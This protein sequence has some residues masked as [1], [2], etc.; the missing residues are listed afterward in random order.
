MG[1]SPV[2]DAGVQ[3]VDMRL[4]PGRELQTVRPALSGVLRQ[5]E[6]GQLGAPALTPELLTQREAAIERNGLQAIFHHGADAHEAHA[7]SDEGAEIA[8]GQIRNPDRGERS[9]FSRSSKCRASPGSVLVFAHDHGPDLGGLAPT[10][11]VWPRRCMS[12]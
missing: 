12:S 2:G 9:C 7:V 11:R 5:V 3:A 6:G 8:G 1:V 4:E 10:S